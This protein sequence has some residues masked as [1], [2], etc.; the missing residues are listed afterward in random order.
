MSKVKEEKFYKN[1][2]KFWNWLWHSNSLASW[3]VLFAIAFIIVKFIFFP[4]ASV[5]LKSSMPFVIVESYSM[6]H[7]YS[8]NRNPLWH[9]SFNDY[10]L[11]HG[12]WY[13]NIGISKQNFSKFP[14]KNGLDAGD[15]AVLKGQQEYNVGEI[16]VYIANKKPIIHRIIKKRCEINVTKTCFYETKG[17]N[18][19]GQI[20]FEKNIRQEQIIGKV[21]FV[22]PKFG[23]IKLLPFKLLGLS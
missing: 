13:E 23:W 12:Y 10:W 15:I 11:N 16:I 3:L 5:M 6:Q 14:F 19:N 18:N 20:P 7:C 2:K 4:I 9:C 8:M 21:I 1:I 22:I 17:D